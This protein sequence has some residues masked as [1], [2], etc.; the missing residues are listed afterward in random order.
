MPAFNA[1]P[2][3]TVFYIVAAMAK[4]KK[5]A[6][7]VAARPVSKKPTPKG[8]SAKVARGAA[9]K[10]SSRRSRRFIEADIHLFSP[11]SEGERADALR[12]LI[13]D[14]RVANM[15]KVGR[16]RVIA[17]EPIVLKPPH[18]LTGHRLARIAIFDYAADRAVDALVDLDDGIVAHLNIS[19]AQPMLA[20]EEEA[21]AVAIALADDRVKNVLSLG[22]EPQVAMHYWSR[23]DSDLAYA[24]RSAAVLFGQTGARPSFVAVIDLL[25]SQVTELV[26][27]EQW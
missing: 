9:A 20:R 22:D 15:A 14:K 27:A 8:K 6:K 23:R 10:T 1:W 3:A 21:A 13:E 4:G 7:K 24:R 19:L 26:P 16:Y 25:D 11:L 2:S 18:A 12:T 17:V 5:P